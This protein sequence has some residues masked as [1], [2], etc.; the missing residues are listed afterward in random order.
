MLI[1]NTHVKGFCITLAF[2]KHKLAFIASKLNVLCVMT[3]F[4]LYS[5]NIFSSLTR[6]SQN[7]NLRDPHFVE[8]VM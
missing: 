8:L 5:S 1:I 4:Q 6:E 3:S 7:F 2:C